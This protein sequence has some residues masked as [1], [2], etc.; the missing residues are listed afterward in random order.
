MKYL[1]RTK[2]VT[3][4][5]LFTVEDNYCDSELLKNNTCNELLKKYTLMICP[6]ISPF[7]GFNSNVSSRDPKEYHEIVFKYKVEL[8]QQYLSIENKYK[9]EN[10]QDKEFSFDII[11]LD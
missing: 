10:E 9:K 4:N 2:F 7:I 3:N 8:I 1:I 6:H 5:D 11:K